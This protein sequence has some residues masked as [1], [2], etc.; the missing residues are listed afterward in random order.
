MTVRLRLPYAAGADRSGE[1]RQEGQLRHMQSGRA[2]L[3]HLYGQ[4]RVGDDADELL[5]DQLAQ[6]DPGTPGYIADNAT[7]RMARINATR[8]L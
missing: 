5:P 8:P 1:D 2:M 7:H 6:S 4:Q 3:L